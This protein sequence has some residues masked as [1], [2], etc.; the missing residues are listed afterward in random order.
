MDFGDI[1]A[2]VIENA[3]EI[4]EHARLNTSCNVECGVQC[5]NERKYHKLDKKWIF[6]FNRTCFASC[7]CSF[8]YE[9]ALT[10]E[11]QEDISK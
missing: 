3:D 4:L 6:G 7:N 5:W 9:T 1:V 2:P 8:K 11:Q 10:K